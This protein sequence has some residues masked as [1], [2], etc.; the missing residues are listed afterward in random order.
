MIIPAKC[1][2]PE[3]LSSKLQ[4]KSF[5]LSKSGTKNETATLL[6]PLRESVEDT[7]IPLSFAEF[8]SGNLNSYQ[9]TSGI[10]TVTRVNQINSYGS[11]LYQRYLQNN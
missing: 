7:I 5:F 6:D 9:N 11:L 1:D 8:F 2:K 4:C 3:F 10:V